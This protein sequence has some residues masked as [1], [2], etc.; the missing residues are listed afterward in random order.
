MSR[1]NAMRLPKVTFTAP[2]DSYRPNGR[3][4]NQLRDEID[5]GNLPAPVTTP[6]ELATGAELERIKHAVFKLLPS[7]NY[8]TFISSFTAAQQTQSP[9]P[10]LPTTDLSFFGIRELAALSSEDSLLTFFESKINPLLD[11]Y[12]PSAWEIFLLMAPTWNSNLID[13]TEVVISIAKR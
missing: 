5:S 3:A 9:T 6:W 10:P 4:Y 2:E 7:N 8:P 12:G 11:P 13:L 1:L